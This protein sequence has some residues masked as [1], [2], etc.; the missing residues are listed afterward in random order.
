MIAHGNAPMLR[1]PV[2]APA[3]VTAVN[4]DAFN[5]NVT[6]RT[7]GIRIN[8]LT[9]ER[10]AACVEYQNGHAVFVIPLS[11]GFIKMYV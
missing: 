8:Q 1:R 11:P 5:E 6:E 4:P 10:R 2:Q 3:F 9:F 7:V